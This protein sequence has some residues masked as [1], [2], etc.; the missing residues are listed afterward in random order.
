MLFV[1]GTRRF[2]KEVIYILMVGVISEIK[3]E[4]FIIDW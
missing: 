4:I 1:N 3:M 2:W